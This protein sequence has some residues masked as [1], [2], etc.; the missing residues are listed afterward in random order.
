MIYLVEGE[1]D[2][3]RLRAIGLPGTCNPGGAGKWLRQY[4]AQLQ[5]ASIERVVILPDN[6]PP[7][8][9]H[10]E[11]IARSCHAAGLAVKVVALP[12]LQAKGDVSDWLDAGGTKADLAALVT[13]APPYVP[14][15][16]P[17]PMISTEALDLVTLAD[18]DA[19]GVEWVWPGRLARGKY[20]LSATPDSARAP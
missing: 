9:A 1:K 19:E 13:A 17:T 10:A 16:E 3:D 7:G 18:V 14:T 6:D 15:T 4:V 8:H 11:A 2:A 12:D 20:T 5:A